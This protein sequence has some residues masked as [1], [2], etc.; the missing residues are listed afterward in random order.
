MAHFGDL[1][2]EYYV[3]QS[4]TDSKS[5]G[6]KS[7]AFKALLMGSMFKKLRKLPHISSKHQRHP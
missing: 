4:V 1:I 6:K 7:Q 3:N 5:D 2:Q